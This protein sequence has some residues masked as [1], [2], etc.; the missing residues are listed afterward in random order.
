MCKRTYVTHTHQRSVGRGSNRCVCSE[1]SAPEFSA[2]SGPTP[3]SGP[4]GVGGRQR[5]EG[6]ESRVRRSQGMK[7]LIWATGRQGKN[8]AGRQRCAREVGKVS[9]F[10]TS[11]WG[12]GEPLTVAERGRHAIR[13]GL[14][15]D[16]FPVTLK[17]SRGTWEPPVQTNSQG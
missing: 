11:S 10:R 2:C 12:T 8:R 15:E 17:P 1:G 16:C 9:G 6:T 13:T 5:R 7:E 3:H 4:R 14:R